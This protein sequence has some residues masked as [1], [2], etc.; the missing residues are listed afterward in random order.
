MQYTC[1][2]IHFECNKYITIGYH[3]LFGCVQ[4]CNLLR[5]KRINCNYCS[6]R[7]SMISTSIVACDECSL[8]AAIAPRRKRTPMCDMHACTSLLQQMIL[9]YRL[10]SLECR[11]TSAR[12]LI[13][14]HS[15]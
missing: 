12:K 7:L 6:G 2:M 9:V 10:P 4:Y 8:R 3:L 1:A 11:G 15:K 14:I 13:P 5:P